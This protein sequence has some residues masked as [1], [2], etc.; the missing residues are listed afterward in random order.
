[1]D[2]CSYWD[3]VFFRNVTMILSTY[4]NVCSPF[5]FSQLDPHSTLVEQCVQGK[6]IVQVNVKI[7]FEG[8]V[9]KINIL[10][11][12]KPADEGREF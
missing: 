3:S 5:F 4:K 2:D 10:D 6:G 9:K 12:L 1:M 8:G 11:V 7:S